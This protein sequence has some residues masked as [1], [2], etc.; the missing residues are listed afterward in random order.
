MNDAELKRAALRTL[1]GM[2]LLSKYL[3]IRSRRKRAPAAFDDQEQSHVGAVH[4]PSSIWFGHLPRHAGGDR[5][6]LIRGRVCSAI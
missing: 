2:G 4:V 1:E 6:P 5:Q 3:A